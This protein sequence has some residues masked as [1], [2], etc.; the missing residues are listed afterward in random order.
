MFKIVLFFGS[1]LSLMVITTG[2]KPKSASITSL[3]RKE[4][5]GLVSEAEFAMTIRELVRAEKLLTQACALE[6]DNG[7]TWI[8]LGMIRVRLGRK[9]AA[10]E[11]YESAL[12][13]YAEAYALQPKS[14]QLYLQQVYLL[15]LMGR[16]TDARSVLAEIQKQHGTDPE[17]RSFV[18]SRQLDAM[19]QSPQ[20]KEIAL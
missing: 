4:A 11:A 5:A 7:K 17:V 9:P 6:F 13:A 10:K 20:F 1:L 18:Q 12:H 8:S 2:C 16:M 14:A 15:A 19:A 3:Q